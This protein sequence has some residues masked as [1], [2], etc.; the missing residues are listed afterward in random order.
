[1]SAL[2]R[3]FAARIERRPLGWL[4]TDHVCPS[5]LLGEILAVSL[6]LSRAAVDHALRSKPPG[7]RLG[8]HLVDRGLLT[9]EQLYEALSAQRNVPLKRLNPGDAPPN[10]A[11]HFPARVVRKCRTIPFRV[12][13]GCLLVAGP[14]LPTDEVE[15][16][17]KEHTQL[18]IRFHLITPSNFDRLER[19]LIA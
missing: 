11:R 6:R 3:Y 13:S 8:E 16:E 5:R 9:E 2:C 7:V 4:K 19:E 18:K 10:V 17:L 1:V 15:R 12:E 14:E